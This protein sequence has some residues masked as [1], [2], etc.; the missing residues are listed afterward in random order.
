MDTDTPHQDTTATT[1]PIMPTLT[2]AILTLATI[3]AIILATP[4]LAYSNPRTG[5]FMEQMEGLL[6]LAEQ[7]RP[8]MTT[9]KPCAS[10][11]ANGAEESSAGINL[12]TTTRNLPMEIT[13][14]L[15][16]ETFSSRP[17]RILTT[18]LTTA[19]RTPTRSPTTVLE[20]SATTE[21]WC[22]LLELEL[23]P[24]LELT[25]EQSQQSETNLNRR[26]SSPSCSQFDHVN[27]TQ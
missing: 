18:I 8:R 2:L 24:T 14:S 6:P 25:L 5:L 1:L 11:E 4:P 19:I 10:G 9:L 21:L 27:L 16:M 12:S 3:L 13:R 23:E 15:L 17:S 7:V 26:M 20:F 22:L